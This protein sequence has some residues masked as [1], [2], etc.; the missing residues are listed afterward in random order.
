LIVQVESPVDFASVEHHSVDVSSYLLRQDLDTYFRVLIG[1]TYEELVK[2]FWVKDEV[3]D[4]EDAKLE[5]IQKIN[6]DPSL[7]GKSRAEKGLEEFTRTEIRS[8]I[9]GIP[10]IIT[11]DIIARTARCSNEGKFQWNLNSK[12]SSWIKTM[13][14]TFHK[15]R[16]SNKLIDM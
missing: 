11:E 12:T 4:K 7:E 16:T 1:P 9:M 10:I 8:T 13:Y 6:G 2:N 14:D 3:Y 5:E 15:G